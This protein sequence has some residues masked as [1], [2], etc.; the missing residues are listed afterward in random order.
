MGDNAAMLARLAGYSQERIDALR[1]AGVLH[2]EPAV[3]EL[4]V[5][6]ELG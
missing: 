2:Q 1:E 3:A 4:R 6:G 5:R